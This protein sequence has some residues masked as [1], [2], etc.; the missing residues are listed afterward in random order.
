M[1]KE[2]KLGIFVVVCLIGSVW[3]IFKIKD[4]RLEKGYRLHIYFNDTGGI[5]EKSWVRSAGVK[6]GKVE[7]I[8]L[9]KGR[10]KITVWIWEKYKIHSDAKVRIVSTGLLGVK[11]I[12]IAAGS[13]DKPLLRDG[14]KIEGIEPVSIEKVISIGFETLDR[15][16]GLFDPTV[17][18]NLFSLLGNA[19]E[20]MEK[21]NTSLKKEKVEEAIENIY[22]MSAKLNQAGKNVEML[23][24]DAVPKIN[25]TVENITK[26]SDDVRDIIREIKSTET[27]V[28]ALMQDKKIVKDVRD[29]IVALKR[30]SEH[31]EDVISRIR[32]INSYWNYVLRYNTIDNVAVNDFGIFIYPRGS[33]FYYL[34]VN[35]LF[36]QGYGT[37]TDVDRFNTFTGVIGQEVIPSLSLYG[38]I[39]R[40][41]AGIGALWRPA[42]I[43]DIDGCM[44]A[45]SRRTPSIQ[46]YFIL[47]T[48]LSLVPWLFVGLQVEDV[49]LVERIKYYPYVRIYLYD[50]DIAYLLGLIGFAKP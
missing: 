23:V 38:G 49:L 50:E 32:K 17:K 8:S 47:S 42:K 36:Q 44:F 11:Y 16:S 7:S 25:N 5:V 13:E 46:P 40:S 43:V 48:R 35:N 9:E 2:L 37:G 1:S 39:I 12:D 33:K 22:S 21:V 29:T 19:T 41:Y 10:A 15:I 4:I 24:T 14:D 6:I 28:G 30:T 26:A 20:V 34:G 18:N 3:I 45:F 31:A 27:V